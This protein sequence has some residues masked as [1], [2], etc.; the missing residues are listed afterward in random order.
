MKSDKNFHASSDKE[1]C[2]WR[3]NLLIIIS[4]V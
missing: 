1:A 3:E 4:Y 2:L